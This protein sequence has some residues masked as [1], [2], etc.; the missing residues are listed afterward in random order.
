MSSNIRELKANQVLNE[1]WVATYKKEI[2][3]IWWQAYRFNINL[4]ILN[5][6]SNFPFKTF[7]IP[8]NKSPFWRS[9]I[10]S[11][12]DTN[13]SIIWKI[14]CDNGRDV[15]T[16]RKLKNSISAN[17]INEDIKQQFYT[18]LRKNDFNKNVSELETKVTEIR[19]NF[20]SHFIRDYNI[21]DKTSN[22]DIIIKYSDLN[23]FSD[24]FEILFNLLNFNYAQSTKSTEDNSSFTD[25]N[26]TD[27][28]KI[29]NG[30]VRNSEA[31][32]MKEQKPDDFEH[33]IKDIS[34]KDLK[35]IND[36]RIKFNMSQIYRKERKG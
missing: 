17:I 1:S 4:F 6:I 5:K 18:S 20:L 11:F 35:I 26:N 8:F 14:V 3:V 24:E 12:V 27:V 28:D 13:V 19:H 10:S 33:W 7:D 9:V 31:L 30:L 34:S 32:N 15:L 22:Q 25:K 29:F 36:Y 21:I 2:E 23:E 16:I